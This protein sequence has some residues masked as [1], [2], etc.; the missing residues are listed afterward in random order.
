MIYDE[1][2]IAL[3]AVG[4][5]VKTA[6]QVRS[7]LKELGYACSLINMRF[8]KPIDEELIRQVA[9]EHQLVVTMEENV[10]CGGFRRTGDGLFNRI[11]SQVRV[12]TIALPDDYVEH[13]NVELLRKE[14]GIDP[15]TIEKK[16][17][18]SYIGI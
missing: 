16:I 7:C 14:V 18:A 2:E 9:K 12:L 17:L 8:V 13:G 6:Q 10:A 4:S 11:G 15:Q 5:M 1:A 3:L